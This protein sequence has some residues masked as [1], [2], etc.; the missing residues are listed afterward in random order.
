MKFEC[1]K[2]SCLA[3]FIIGAGGCTTF[4]QPR[5]YG[6]IPNS[7]NT[8]TGEELC[9]DFM[10]R[11]Q[12][13]A[14]EQLIAGWGFAVAGGL[15]TMTGGVIGPGEANG[16]SFGDKLAENRNVIVTA[17]GAVLAALGW[18]FVNRAGAAAD[19][20][21]ASSKVVAGRNQ[22]S[23]AELY[24]RCMDVRTTWINGVIASPEIQRLPG[25]SAPGTGASTG[26]GTGA[27]TGTGT[28]M[29][30]GTGTGASTGT[31]T[32][33][34]TGTGT[35]TSTGTATGTAVRARR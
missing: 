18:N 27:S 2:V 21:S 34:S 28:G 31:G 35:G 24:A 15:T 7:A 26:T 4:P 9:L 11:T 6:N 5:P 20:S 1:V 25:V 29:S 30:T 10:H 13:Q 14:S 8:M 33:T 32:G 23:D 12:T 22:Y 3:A 17:F 19:A 16:N